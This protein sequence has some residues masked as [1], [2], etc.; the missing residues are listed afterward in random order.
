[1]RFAHAE[2]KGHAMTTQFLDISMTGM[3]FVVDR[4]TAP[5]I[6]ESIKVEV[7]LDETSSIAWWAKVIRVEEYAPHKWYMPKDA[8]GDDSTKVL[9]AVSFQDMP[10]GH[11]EKIKRALDRKFVEVAKE[12]RA[13]HFRNFAAMWASHSWHFILYIGLAI[14]TFGMLWYLAQ[15]SANYG[16]KGAPWGERFTDGIFKNGKW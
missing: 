16:E 11:V 9:V 3:A 15:P 12:K 1:M 6:F 10:E 7:P 4:D 5:F 13:D 2:D 14:A 8:F